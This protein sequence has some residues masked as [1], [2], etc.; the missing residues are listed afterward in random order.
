MTILWGRAPDK[1]ESLFRLLM[2]DEWESPSKAKQLF[3]IGVMGRDTFI[4][5]SQAKDLQTLIAQT[6]ASGED[7]M[8]IAIAQRLQGYL[9]KQRTSIV[10]PDLSDKRNVAGEILSSPK[11]VKAIEEQA[12]TSGKS[13]A[14]VKAEAQGYLGEIT[15]NYSHSVVRFF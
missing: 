7:G 8:T 10:G 4:H 9:D 3:N 11:V 14:V 6:Q 15:S 2:A 13:I 12:A 5:F 1:E